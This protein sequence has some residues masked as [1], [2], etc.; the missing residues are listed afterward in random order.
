MLITALLVA[1]AHVQS[2]D[3]TK[4]ALSQLIAIAETPIDITGVEDIEPAK[5]DL[6]QV[7]AQNTMRAIFTESKLATTSFAFVESSFAVAIKGFSADMFLPHI[8]EC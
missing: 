6:P 2:Y 1:E 5:W 7:H 3:L 8:T 4:S